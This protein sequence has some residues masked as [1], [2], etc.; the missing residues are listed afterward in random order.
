[1]IYKSNREVQSRPKTRTG[2]IPCLCDLP[3][4]L[5]A[6][7]LSVALSVSRGHI[8]NEDFLFGFWFPLSKSPP[9][10]LS[11][12]SRFSFSINTSINWV[13]HR[14]TEV[15]SPQEVHQMWFKGTLKHYLTPNVM[16]REKT[17]TNPVLEV[18]S[19]IYLVYWG[20]TS[21]QTM[22]W[23]H[24]PNQQQEMTREHKGLRL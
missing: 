15:W 21:Q 22:L 13:N 18:Y 3:V 5:R 1:M 6:A 2:H 12:H 17:Q 24:H 4:F 11:F 7:N 20:L 9:F 16:S 10:S 19:L 23:E 8:I 14:I